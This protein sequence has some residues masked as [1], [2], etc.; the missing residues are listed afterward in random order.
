MLELKNICK[1]YRPKKGVPVQALKNVSL[2]FTE[3]GMVFILGKSGCGKSTLL[4]CIGGL[5]TFDS[6]ELVI[7]G[8]SSKDFSGS[9]FDSY[10]NTFIGFIFQ[11]YN[12]LSE[13]NVEKNIALAL[14]LQGKKATKERVQELLRDVDLADQGKRKTNELSGGQKQR[15]AI[16]RALIKDPEIIIADEPTGALDSVTGKQVFDTLK[17]LSKDKLVI[18]V[19]HDREFA[20]NYADRIIEM[21]DGVVISDET[22]RHIEGQKLN[23]GVSVIGDDVIH[24]KAGH[25]VTQKEVEFITKYIQKR[26]DS[27]AF[28]SL[29]PNTNV[30]FRDIAKIDDNNASEKFDKT[31]A[32]DLKTRTY[33]RKD[34]KLIRSRLKFKDSFKMGASG[35]KAKPVRLVFTIILSFIAFAM[36]GIVDTASAFNFVDNTT[37]SI[38]DSNIKYVSFT[39]HNAKFREGKLQYYDTSNSMMT[40]SDIEA[41]SLKVDTTLQPVY[42]LGSRYSSGLSL[43]ESFK[44]YESSYYSNTGYYVT[45]AGGI[46]E[47]TKDQLEG[48][49]CKILYGA[50]PISSTSAP[51]EVLITK[52]QLESFKQYGYRENTSEG[53]T[54]ALTS[55]ELTQNP[56]LIVGKVLRFNQQEFKIVGVVDTNFDM[57]RYSVLAGS[58][59]STDGM[60]SSS[61]S[62][63]SMSTYLLSMELSDIQNYSIHNLLVVGKDVIGNILSSGSESISAGIG[64]N[65][66]VAYSTRVMYEGGYIDYQPMLFSNQITAVATEN[67]VKDYVVGEKNT[68]H[69]AVE[70]LYKSGKTDLGENGIMLSYEQLNNLYNAKMQSNVDSS[71]RKNNENVYFAQDKLVSLYGNNTTFVSE[72]INKVGVVEATYGVYAE[73]KIFTDDKAT[74]ERISILMAILSRMNTT[75]SETQEYLQAKALFNTYKSSVFQTDF[76]AIV[77]VLNDVEGVLI[78]TDSDGNRSE[79]TSEICGI[80]VEN[81]KNNIE[82]EFDTTML[83]GNQVN[84]TIRNNINSRGVYSFAIG[85]MPTDEKKIAKLVDFHNENRKIDDNTWSSNITE[86]ECEVKEIYLLENEVTLTMDKVIGIVEEIATVLLYVGIGFCVF[87]AL[88]L[89][90]FISTSISYKKREIGILRALG[91]KKSDVFGIFF[92]ESLI[93]A[94]INFV[95]ATI[96]TG[97]VC[98][99]INTSLRSEYGL[100]ISIFNF[101]VRQIGLIMLVSVAVAFVSS[102][103]PV[104]RIAKKQPIDAINNR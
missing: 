77:S 43:R 78:Y 44:S 33:D 10:R 75:N 101:G 65:S 85:V 27:E 86:E 51:Y 28:I 70:Y 36:F 37:K 4:N 23:E 39:K 53:T 5:D 54:N 63:D 88:M 47:F 73:Y 25:V 11:E 32:E 68:S 52:Y 24:I 64:T 46:V 19:S 71:G 97:V 69:T 56:E 48:M 82:H 102:L 84:R 58:G 30:K 99:I 95:L 92:N 79:I 59:T 35:L 91:S 15:I 17:K 34:L 98:G 1:T 22:K 67:N 83:V 12:I 8:K 60:L 72:L 94:A 16:A 14:E 18:V 38:I 31:T 76:D 57:E 13:F 26:G 42:T 21:K 62:E 66:S 81:T 89:M 104:Y 90:N 87:A 7:K 55:E 93:I 96:A 74:N 50:M 80:F 100:L 49:G 41:L 40:G 9:D 3:K 2:K 20:E 103:L 6:G 29:N 45:R 61:S